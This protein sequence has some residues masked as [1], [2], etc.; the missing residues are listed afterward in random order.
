MTIRIVAASA[1]L[2]L[3]LVAT[4]AASAVGLLT[5]H[6]ISAALAAEA[7]QVAVAT[8]AGQNFPVSAVVLDADG[9]EQAF[10]RGDDAGIH[11]LQM[12]HNK[13][14]TSVSFRTNTSV[15]DAQAARRP[16]ALAGDRETAGSGVGTG[17]G[18]DSRAAPTT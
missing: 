15:L 5:T 16:A 4:Q 10:L 1:A 9:V 12:A 11:T 17:R 8:C 3:S 18:R 6:R 2:V 7:V 14:Y 13:A